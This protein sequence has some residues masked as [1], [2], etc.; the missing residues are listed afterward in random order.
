MTPEIAA[1]LVAVL[2][3]LAGLIAALTKRIDTR[4]TA[5]AT[6]AANEAV[7]KRVVE[8]R[9]LAEAR[10]A[11]ADDCAER[12]RLLERD[13]ARL[14]GELE[15]WRGDMIK[16]FVDGVIDVLTSRIDELR[17]RTTVQV[18]ESHTTTSVSTPQA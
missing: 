1:A 15:V 18:D 4:A 10:G 5:A 11:A 8:W 9:D 12:C 17:P 16:G 3:A 7:E 13:V 6:H 2:A 14:R